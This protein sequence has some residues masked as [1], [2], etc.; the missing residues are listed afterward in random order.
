[1]ETCCSFLFVF[2][3]EIFSPSFVSTPLPVCFPVDSKR[4]SE[5]PLC[6][7]SC[8]IYTQPSRWFSLFCFYKREIQALEGLVPFIGVIRAGTRIW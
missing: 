4:R 5:T 7:S 6:G 1:M 3:V 8:L 2:K